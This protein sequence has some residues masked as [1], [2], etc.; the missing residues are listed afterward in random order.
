MISAALF[1][2]QIMRSSTT[3]HTLNETS[4]LY[5]LSRFASCQLMAYLLLLLLVFAKRM[6]SKTTTLLMSGRLIVAISKWCQLIKEWNILHHKTITFLNKLWMLNS[7]IVTL[8]YDI[9]L[10]YLFWLMIWI[11]INFVV[12]CNLFS[13]L[14]LG[15]RCNRV[16]FKDILRLTVWVGS[17]K[18]SCSS[19]RR[20]VKRLLAMGSLENILILLDVLLFSIYPITRLNCIF[21]I[22]LGG[23]HMLLNLLEIFSP[24]DTIIPQFIIFIL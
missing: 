20:L 23:Y 12:M 5:I 22:G 4:R 6:D 14:L 3:N 2:E 9:W 7:T 1:I 16:G 8:L 11:A 19:F 13:L 24:L 10:I 15:R 21:L 18:L 17:L